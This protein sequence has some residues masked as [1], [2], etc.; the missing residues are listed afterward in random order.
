MIDLHVLQILWWVLIGTLLIGF[1]LTDGFDMGVGMLLPFVGKTDGERRVA[2]NAVGATW[3]GNQVWFITAGGATFAAWPVVYATAFSGF[4]I[5]LLLVL[6]ALFFRPVGFDYRNKLQSRA[7]RGFWDWGIFAGSFVPALVFGVAFGNL[8]QGVPFAI[9]ADHRI[10]Y[11]GNFFQLLNPFALLSGVLSVTMLLAHGAAFLNVKTEGAVRER[12]RK[13]QIVASL[14]GAV[15]FVLAGVWV[16]RALPGLRHAADGSIQQGPGYWMENYR[17]TAWTW[18]APALGIAG[19]LFSALAGWR[20]FGRVAFIGS[21][22]AIT[23]VIFTAGASMFPF[24]MPSS[25]DLAH[26]LTI[27][28]ASS[29]QLTLQIML[30]AVIIFLPLI[31]AYTTWVYRV[32]RGRIS[33]QHIERNSASMY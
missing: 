12:G 6:F 33:E 14:L 23:G 25:F 1:A 18:A 21:G 11:H 20:R 24:V 16:D 28:N 17:A 32:M 27:W 7:W 5:A 15:L 9:D 22:L 26:S 8:L 13:V 29:S 30:F 10:S 2:V 3:E 19:A 31:L 4:Y